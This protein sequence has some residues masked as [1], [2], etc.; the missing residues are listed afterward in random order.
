MPAVVRS[1]IASIA[2]AR[3]G[4]ARRGSRRFSPPGSSERASADGAWFWRETARRV[5]VK[6]LGSRVPASGDSSPST[7][8]WRPPSGASRSRGSVP[9][10]MGS[11]SRPSRSTYGRRMRSQSSGANGE[12]PDEAGAFEPERGRHTGPGTARGDDPA[13][14]LGEENY[15]KFLEDYPEYFGRKVTAFEIW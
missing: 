8:S 5:T 10:S 2:S 14:I 11:I 6:S 4:C 3:D 1:I 9:G 7:S 13:L 12:A 15:R